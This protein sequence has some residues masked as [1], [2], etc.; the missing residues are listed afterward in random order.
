MSNSYFPKSIAD[1]E[2]LGFFDWY[3]AL[4]EEDI[5]EIGRPVNRPE[6][7]T[8]LMYV[9]YLRFQKLNNVVCFREKMTE[10]DMNN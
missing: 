10:N 7:E 3:K 9:R 2:I 6:K 8:W 1:K 4:K 5:K